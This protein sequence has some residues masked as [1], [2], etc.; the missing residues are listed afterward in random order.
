MLERERK[1]SGEGIEQG[2]RVR[3]GIL[4]PV[5]EEREREQRAEKREQE[6]RGE[7]KKNKRERQTIP[8]KK[9]CKHKLLIMTRTR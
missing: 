3:Q 1:R 2:E 8:L 6:R 9:E 7:E 5:K 4:I